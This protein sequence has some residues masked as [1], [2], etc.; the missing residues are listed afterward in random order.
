MQEE[1]V[2]TVI[3]LKQNLSERPQFICPTVIYVAWLKESSDKDLN[4]RSAA[5]NPNLKG[6]VVK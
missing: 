5:K 4:F 2:A 1:K 6:R 3:I